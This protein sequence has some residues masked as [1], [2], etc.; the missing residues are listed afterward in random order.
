[1]LYQ[2]HYRVSFPNGCRTNLSLWFKQTLTLSIYNFPFKGK[3]YEHYFYKGVLV[4]VK[5][6]FYKLTL[7]GIYSI[8]VDDPSD[9]EFEN[10]AQKN[11]SIE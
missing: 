7:S 4:Y 1:M 3:I 8:R 5:E 6:P 11:N 9:V 10:D 2:T